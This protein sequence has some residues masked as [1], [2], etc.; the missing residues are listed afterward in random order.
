MA[1]LRKFTTEF[2]VYIPD[3]T[4]SNIGEVVLTYTQPHPVRLTGN[5]QPLSVKRALEAYGLEVQHAYSLFVRACGD[6]GYLQPLQRLHN[7]K[8]WLEIKQIETY[9]TYLLIL[10]EEVEQDG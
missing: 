9:P 7:G 2:T 8:K 1:F 6:Y 10:V 3:E 4:A 5:L